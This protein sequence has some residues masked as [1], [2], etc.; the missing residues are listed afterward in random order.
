MVYGHGGCYLVQSKSVLWVRYSKSKLRL[1][2]IAVT[3]MDDMNVL[4]FT[5]NRWGAVIEYWV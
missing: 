3:G 2:L 1:H 4:L 5:G